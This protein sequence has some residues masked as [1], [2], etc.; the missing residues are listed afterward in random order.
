MLIH[1]QYELWIYSIAI[2][3]IY[4]TKVNNDCFRSTNMSSCFCAGISKY[5]RHSEATA[6]KHYDF[7]AVKASARNRDTI[8]KLIG[9][10]ETVKVTFFVIHYKLYL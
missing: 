4:V 1:Q 5:L 2:S 10:K 9:G 7:G 3:V 6:S 8:V